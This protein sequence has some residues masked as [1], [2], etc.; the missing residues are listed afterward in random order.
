MPLIPMMNLQQT[1]RLKLIGRHSLVCTLKAEF[2]ASEAERKR[3]E[4]DAKEVER[5]RLRRFRDE[6]KVRKR[7]HRGGL[8]HLLHAVDSHNDPRARTPS[9]VPLVTCLPSSLD[10]RACSAVVPLVLHYYYTTCALQRRIEDE[11]AKQKAEAA[12]K[13]QALKDAM[14]EATAMQYEADERGK[15]RL[16]ADPTQELQKKYRRLQAEQIKIQKERDAELARK[17]AAFEKK[18]KE[19]AAQRQL[20][21]EAAEREA[22]ETAKKNAERQRQDTLER[23]AA[24]K[25]RYARIA[26]EMRQKIEEDNRR[27]AEAERQA[28]LNLKEAKEAQYEAALAKAVRDARMVDLQSRNDKELQEVRKRGP[29]LLYFDPVWTEVVSARRQA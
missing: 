22:E 5:A 13:R 11:A 7:S 10:L 26:K 17:Q 3:K 25:A 28:E 23:E 27:K 1:Q 21:V 19:E 9:S 8:T 20:Q 18:K 24:E 12:A 4:A 15:M 16:K 2:S 6:Q 29:Q 14:R